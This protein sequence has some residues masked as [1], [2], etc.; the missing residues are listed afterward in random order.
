MSMTVLAELPLS[1]LSGSATGRRG[2]ARS[3]SAGR[4]RSRSGSR[5]GA[6]DEPTGVVVLCSLKLYPGGRL[7]VRT[8][9]LRD[10]G[11]YPPSP[12]HAL[13]ALHPPRAWHAP[14]ALAA[15]ARRDPRDPS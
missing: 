13:S 10:G 2:R 6:D 7:D 4:R 12:W 8:G 14:R 11:E 15:D 3:S 9:A 1:E 5:D